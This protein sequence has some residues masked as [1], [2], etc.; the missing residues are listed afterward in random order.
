MDPGLGRTI[1]TDTKRLTRSSRTCSRTPSNSPSTVESGSAS[2]HRGGRVGPPITRSSSSTAS[3]VAFEVVRHRDR[4]HR[5]KSSAS[6]S[7]PSSRPMP[8]PAASTAAPGW[9][10]RSV[11]S[12]RAFSAV[13]SSF[14]AR[15]ARA[16]PSRCTCRRPTSV[17]T[18][19][20][21]RSTEAESKA[22][23]TGSLPVRAGL[24]PAGRG[25]SGR[26]AR[27]GGGHRRAPDRRGRPPLRAGA[28]RCGARLR[29]SRCWS[30]CGAAMRWR[31]RATTSP[32][33]ISLDVFLPDMLGWTVLNQLK[34]DPALRHIPV[35]IVTL[36]E[37]RQ[38]GLAR[39]A[40]A[41]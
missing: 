4:H 40:F 2:P 39:G 35:Q 11:A 14:A 13:R 21:S 24:G 8:A 25:D 27:A 30:P 26:P 33:P 1:V 6:F 37:D 15:R 41:S 28:G 3:V 16:A 22:A 9:A 38:H 23:R 7:R 12:W 34:Q 18:T 17:P 5:R 36:D 19:A 10:S 20:V 32:P 31:W 29:A